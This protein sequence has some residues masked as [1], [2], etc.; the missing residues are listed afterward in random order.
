MYYSFTVS[1]AFQEADQSPEDE[2][3]P[4]DGEHDEL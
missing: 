1:S 2:E 4:E 3:V